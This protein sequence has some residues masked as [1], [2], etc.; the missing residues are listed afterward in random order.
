M[1]HIIGV[2]LILIPFVWVAYGFRLARY[3]WASIAEGFLTSAL[4]AA[5]IIVG[6]LLIAGVL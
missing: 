4:M 2:V 1:K 6:A 3:S 5:F